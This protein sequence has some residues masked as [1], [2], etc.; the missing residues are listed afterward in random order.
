MN[1][2]WQKKSEAGPKRNGCSISESDQSID[3]Y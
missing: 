1:N 3:P 2:Q